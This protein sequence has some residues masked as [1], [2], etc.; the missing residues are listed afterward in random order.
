MALMPGL[1]TTCS[2]SLCN[3]LIVDKKIVLRKQY[4]MGDKK[5]R[6]KANCLYLTSV[7]LI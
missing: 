3:I 2:I 5:K 1:I 4:A 6:D 7:L